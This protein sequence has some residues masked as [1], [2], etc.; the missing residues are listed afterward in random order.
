VK[1]TLAIVGSHTG[2]RSDV[3]WGRDDLDIWVFNEALSKALTTDANDADKWCERADAVFQMHDPAVWKNPLNRNDRTHAD[4]LKSG[5][6]PVIYMLE[7]FAEV[8]QA[9]KFPLDEVIANTGGL[10][11]KFITSSVALAFALAIYQGYKKIEVYGVEMETETEYVYQR[12]AMGY[13][14]GVMDGIG[15]ELKAYCNFL[16]ERYVYGYEGKVTV[17]LQD[18]HDKIV[19]LDQQGRK[20][21]MITLRRPTNTTHTLRS[22][23]HYSTLMFW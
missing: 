22:I 16:K 15:I 5:N 10:C 21:G 7:A 18:F 2:T 14:F 20:H 19:G 11:T 1:D 9:V 4:W 13:W 23:R 17:D 3:D 8:P 6:T 12:D